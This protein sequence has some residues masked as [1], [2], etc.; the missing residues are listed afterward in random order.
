MVL[1]VRR[2]ARRLLFL[3]LLTLL[4]IAMYG[5]CRFIAVWIT[6]EDPYRI[7]QGSAHKVFQSQLMLVEDATLADRLRLFYWY[8]E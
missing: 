2:W 7:P 8:G 5:G 1:S 4:T 3:V 6:P